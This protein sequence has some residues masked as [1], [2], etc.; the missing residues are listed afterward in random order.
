M[1]REILALVI[2][3]LF[4]LSDFSDA[5]ANVDHTS[6]GFDPPVES[7]STVTPLDTDDL[8]PAVTKE[9]DLPPLDPVEGDVDSLDP[10]S[11]V[12]QEINNHPPLFVQP[13]LV[14]G[15]KPEPIGKA[16]RFFSTFNC[17]HSNLK[18]LNV[19]LINSRHFP[20]KL[21]LSSM[22]RTLNLYPPLPLL[23]SRSL[24]IEVSN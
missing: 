20:S 12:T 9:E 2:L 17:T 19:T 7:T 5:E 21:T 15:A 1:K 13:E 11:P 6:L 24:S 8:F 18:Y 10:R 16:V 23:N 4:L 22:I 3:T 14:F